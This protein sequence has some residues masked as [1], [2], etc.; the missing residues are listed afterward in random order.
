MTPYPFPCSIIK[1]KEVLQELISL[2]KNSIR[3]A[4]L[5]KG[6][7]SK[8]SAKWHDIIPLSC[9]FL[10]WVGLKVPISLPTCIVMCLY[11]TDGPRKIYRIGVSERNIDHFTIIEVVQN[12]F[13]VFQ[14]KEAFGVCFSFQTILTKSF[15]QSTCDKIN[16]AKNLHIIVPGANQNV[17]LILEQQTTRQWLQWKWKC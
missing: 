7:F 3:I 5:I 6:I 14:P 11:W 10:Y 13:K 17:F 15:L 2:N 9:V 1:I 8:S 16:I 12:R 4:K